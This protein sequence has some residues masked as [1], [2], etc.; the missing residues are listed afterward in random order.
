MHPMGYRNCSDG[1]LAGCHLC[2]DNLVP[3]P[4]S[5]VGRL[6][7]VNRECCV[8]KSVAIDKDPCR[9]LALRCQELPVCLGRDLPWQAVAGRSKQPV[10]AAPLGSLK[11]SE[12]SSHVSNPSASP[13]PYP[14]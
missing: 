12:R 14:A 1:V 13:S 5:T 9:V 2:F 10:L 4:D 11:R 8:V 6:K 3:F 7:T